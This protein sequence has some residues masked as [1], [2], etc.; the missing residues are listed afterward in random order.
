MSKH[1][2]RMRG[3]AAAAFAAIASLAIATAALAGGGPALPHANP[4][5]IQPVTVRPVT[6]VVPGATSRP[7]GTTPANR[8]ALPQLRCTNI[9][10]KALHSGSQVPLACFPALPAKTVNN[11]ATHRATAKGAHYRP[12]AA[13]GATIDLTAGASCGSQGALYAIGCSLTWEATNNTDWSATDTYADYQ[14]L[15]NSTTATLVG[16]NGYAAGSPTA[17]TTVLSTQGTYA[18]FVYDTTAQVIASIVYVNAGQSFS[19]GVYQDPYHTQASY[20]YN[21]NTSSAAYIYLPDVSTNDTYVVYVESTSVN[22]FCVYVTPNS[23]PAPYSPSPPPTG[24]PNALI[25]NPANSPGIAAPS[26]QL[27][28]T[29]SLTNAYP[30]GTYSVIVY[31]KTAGQT[32]GQVQVS[33]TGF[34]QYGFLLYG[35]PAPAPSPAAPA[36]P[37]S[38]QFAWDS[39]NDQSTG[40][41]VATVPNQ[42]GGTYRMT[43]SDPDGQVVYVGTTNTIPGTCTLTNNN[44]STCTATSTFTFSAASPTLNA[45][46]TYPNNIW[47]MQL[48][49]PATQTVEASQAFQLMGYSM[50]TQFTIAGITGRTM[51]FGCCTNG[52][53]YNV[54]GSMVFTN[55]ANLNYPNAPDPIAGIEYT[56]GPASGLGIAFT[57]PSGTTGY[58]VTIAVAGCAG[59]YNSA[60]GCTETVTDAS[61]N[62]WT[63][64]DHCSTATPA[65]PGLTN[66][67]I[68]KFTP[69][70]NVTLLPGKSITVSGLTFYAEG[71]TN[72]WSCYAIPCATATSILPADGLSWSSTGATSPAWTP[73]YYGSSGSSIAGTAN[74]HYI[75]SATFPGNTAR[76]VVA[77]ATNPPTTPW[78]N[79]HFYPASFAQGEYQNSTP[80][81]VAAGREDVLT[82]QIANC[83]GS[84]APTPGCTGTSANDLGEVSINFP[85]N[86]DAS[87]I[88]VDPSE[89][90]YA[91]GNY[92]VLATTG[93]NACNTSIATNAICLNAG[94]NAYNATN[95]NK[96]TQPIAP[97]GFAQIWLDVPASQAAYIS[98]ELQVQAWSQSELTWTTLTADG[99]TETPVAGGAV[100]G[101]P[102]DSLSIQGLSL[103]SNLMAAQFNPSTVSPGAT[104]TSYSM[105]FDNTSTAADP[106]PDP[107]DAIVLEQ[108]TSSGWSLT[109][110][111]FSGTG[112]AGWANLSTTGYNVAGND[113]EYWFGVCTNQYTNHTT[114]GPPQPPTAPTN[115]TAAQTSLGAACTA[116]QEQDAIAPGGALTINFT[117]ANTTTGTQTF[118]VYAH[119]ANGGGWSS[120]KTVTVTSSNKTASAKLYSVAQGATDASCDTT[121]NVSANTV[122][123]VS[124]SPNCFIYE[125]TNTSSSGQNIT[126]TNIALP[127]F[128]INGLATGGTDWSLVGSPV[129]EYVVLGTISGGTFKTTGIPAGCAI[130]V[131]NTFNPTPGSTPGQI[132]VTGCTAFTQ[133]TNIAVEFV[134]NTPSTE[135]DSYLLPATIDG[136]T[137]GVAW[138]GSDEVS[139][140]FSL[141]L[142][143]SVD[144]SNPGPGNSH[145]SV[146]CNPAQCTFSG[147]TVNFGEFAANTTITGTD[148][149]RATVVYEGSTVAA[150]C[151]AGAGTVANTWQL[152]VAA[153]AN[154]TTELLTSVDET[155][156][157]SGLTYGTGVNTYFSPTSSVTTLAC[158]N[159]TTS[160][161]FDVLQNFEVQNGVDVSGHQVTITYT[162]IAN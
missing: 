88:T 20:Q 50:Q 161:D 105:T 155:N 95:G 77:Q 139:V 2:P 133:N 47:T 52:T 107:V 89:P 45:P 10:W 138:T 12:L 64:A 119:G 76:N 159:Y 8:R 83:S 82:V 101:S 42:V 150:T 142:A 115:P 59:A 67:C 99:H 126:T 7:N 46:G 141:G 49:N 39:A 9:N 124:K 93:T 30:A 149:V 69:A 32:V 29:W 41:I 146:V 90:A 21:V 148:V 145:P 127:A 4:D 162:L 156:S 152:Q 128:D 108:A 87:E 102:V 112:S 22:T 118:Y 17:H 103:N 13:T 51:V 27:S 109:A 58:G 70:N 160:T 15:P 23:T 6:P 68:L 125:V 14:L 60:G 80:F 36:T 106:N 97:G 55:T 94:G 31:D 122:A 111:T 98:Q 140:A 117:L 157:S 81:A 158:G 19:I 78:I 48:Y 100:A 40:G 38:I 5:V 113:L 11:T 16:T 54:A 85:T 96:A 91:A 18:F 135:S 154:A 134:A 153:S 143:V 66:Q 136:V 147:E 28:L 43:A 92:Y 121:S 57:P 37:S 79:T 65:T 116:A 86:I 34:Q 129:T 72:T 56:T 132:E 137:S 1:G 84:A 73:V 71:G 74:A 33:L 35:T 62:A 61:G 104:T 130:S 53:V 131:A 24:A 123:T 120:P 151:P 114:A 63:L 110:P 44:S 3:I 144:P 25:C 75:G 26:G